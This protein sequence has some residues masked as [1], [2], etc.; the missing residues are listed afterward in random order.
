MEF[1]EGLPTY[2]LTGEYTLLEN[3]EEYV[4]EG[5]VACYKPVA[6][7]GIWLQLYRYAKEGLT[8]EDAVAA[9]IAEYVPEVQGVTTHVSDTWDEAGD[10]NYIYYMFFDTETYEEPYFV[11]VFTFEEEENFVQAVF[12]TPVQTVAIGDSGFSAYI[13]VDMEA[14]DA[15]EVTD[16]PDLLWGY[17]DPEG[18]YANIAAYVWETEATNGEE[19]L[20]ELEEIDVEDEFEVLNS[21]AYEYEGYQCAFAEF[22]ETTDDGEFYVFCIY[23]LVGDKVVCRSSFAPNDDD[24]MKASIPALNWGLI[25]E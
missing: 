18:E 3:S 15:A 13:P 5:V 6:E 11:Q 25:A 1:G 24:Y 7:D 21:T 17:T 12:W 9:D 22:N 19:I 20:A 2:Q 4:E 10:A 16:D 23:T 14:V 8:L